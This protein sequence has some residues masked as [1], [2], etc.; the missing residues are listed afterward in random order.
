MPVHQQLENFPRNPSDK[1]HVPYASLIHPPPSS[2][3]LPFL[4]SYP[5]LLSPLSLFSSDCLPQI[6]EGRKGKGRGREGNIQG[7]IFKTVLTDCL[8][9]RR[10]KD[11]LPSSFLFLWRLSFRIYIC[12]HRQ[13][14]ASHETWDEGGWS[15]DPL[16]APRRK[17]PLRGVKRS[18]WRNPNAPLCSVARDKSEKKEKCRDE[19]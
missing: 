3:S 13:T 14:D 17:S 11:G 15:Q 10:I 9:H 12:F 2:F 8:T 7:E 6:R 1:S 19:G 4:T 5:S 16:D 18:N